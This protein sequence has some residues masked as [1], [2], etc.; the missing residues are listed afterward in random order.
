MES[1]ALPGFFYLLAWA[2]FLG[3][4]ALSIALGFILNYHWVNYARNASA[5]FVATIIYAAG[6]LIILAML[7]GAVLSI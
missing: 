4:T 6:C 7:L 3:A 2:I 5:T 1:G